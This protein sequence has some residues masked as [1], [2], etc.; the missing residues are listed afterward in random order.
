MPGCAR[1]ARTAVARSETVVP[2]AVLAAAGTNPRDSGSRLGHQ[3]AHAEKP[4]TR[5]PRCAALIIFWA[6]LPALIQ[7][8][9][10]PCLAAAMKPAMPLLIDLSAR[11]SNARMRAR[12]AAGGLSA[13]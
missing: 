6:R 12:S 10:F 9:W 11:T 2:A 5:A 4:Y 1:C 13:R 8:V 3:R 7:A